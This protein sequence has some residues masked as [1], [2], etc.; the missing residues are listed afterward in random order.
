MAQLL[1]IIARHASELQDNSISDLRSN[2]KTVSEVAAYINNNF[3]QEITLASISEKFFIS[4]CYFSRVFSRATGISFKEYLNGVR[5][6][7]AQQMLV[8]TNKTITNI[9]EAVGYKTAS[10]FGRNFTSIVGMTPSE[11]RRL[12]RGSR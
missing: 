6:K 7:E 3:S 2:H 12:R 8:N 10:H 9:S 5:I 4:P 11:Y 1:L